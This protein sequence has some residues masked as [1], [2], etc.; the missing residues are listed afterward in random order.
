VRPVLAILAVFVAGCEARV[1]PAENEAGA[2]EA[3]ANQL[4]LDARGFGVKVD[5]PSVEKLAEIKASSDSGLLYPG[6]QLGGLHVDARDD[7]ASKVDLRFT[8]RDSLDLVARWY[9][10]PARAQHF[11]ID[12]AMHDG[13]AYE[14]RGRDKDGDGSFRLRLE[15][16]A[17][18]GGTAGRL[19]L[20]GG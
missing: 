20:A 3:Q 7:A 2:A 19:T 15:P 4:S 14:M 5:I 8:S 6:A 16:A 1:G 13:A 12:S 11:T 18:G 10:D 17:A 9:R